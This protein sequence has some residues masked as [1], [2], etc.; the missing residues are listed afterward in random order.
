M[1]T[2]RPRAPTHG[3]LSI[4][5]PNSGTDLIPRAWFLAPGRFRSEHPVVSDGETVTAECLVVVRD[6]TATLDYPDTAS[7]RRN[8]IERGQ[9]VLEFRD[10]RRLG[11]PA[12]RWWPHGSSDV[13]R[14]GAKATTWPADLVLPEEQAAGGNPLFVANPEE[15]AASVA[16]F[17]AANVDDQQVVMGNNPRYFV[18]VQSG[19]KHLFGL[20]KFVVFH[21]IGI[22]D[23]LDGMWLE[24]SGTPARDHIEK[25]TGLPWEPLTTLPRALQQEF[26]QRFRAKRS[27]EAVL[28]A[29]V[30]SLGAVATKAAVRTTTR[31][32][33]RVMSPQELEQR[34]ARQSELGR[35][36][37]KIALRFE[38][39]R[40]AERLGAEAYR[41]VKHVAKD[42][43]S[44]GCDIISDD[45]DGRR[46]IEVKASTGP[47][48]RFFISEGELRMLRSVGENGYLYLV[49]ITDEKK[50][51]G[52]VEVIANAGAWL[53]APD[54]LHP[55]AFEARRPHKP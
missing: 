22:D 2:P 3:A 45:P 24:T 40:L 44:A 15:L 10:E 25:L 21:G 43:V 32:S 33:R 37:E 19:T 30:L 36:G 48:R 7:N 52:E 49:R 35:V 5:W 29:K 26:V 6:S 42:D 34:L 47:V 41:L 1:A 18:H 17:D 50:A 51:R 14:E 12:A 53:D 55:V 54:V 20:S 8:G 16:T 31:T 27:L 28:G 11:A 46:Y 38:R 9:T 23:Y 4:S 13:L 39:E